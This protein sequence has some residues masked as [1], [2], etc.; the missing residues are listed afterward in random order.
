MNLKTVRHRGST[1]VSDRPI[2]SWLEIVSRGPNASQPALLSYAEF[3]KAA[4]A[5]SGQKL[6]RRTLQFYSSPRLRLVPL[7]CYAKGHIS[8]YRHPEDTLR[9]ALLLYLRASYWMPI[10]LVREVLH[11]LRPKHYDLVMEGL[12]SGQEILALVRGDVSSA[13]RALYDRL[14]RI[15]TEVRPESLTHYPVARP[16]MDI[17]AALDQFAV[18]FRGQGGSQNRAGRAENTL[19]EVRN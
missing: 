2:L 4:A 14:A 5:L 8:H 18:V 12:L 6:T 7:P 16:G 1:Q 19:A 15:L 3:L 10:K 13:G 17:H 9:L 11:G